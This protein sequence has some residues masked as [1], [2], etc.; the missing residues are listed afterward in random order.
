MG[1][2]CAHGDLGVEAM[3]RARTRR[4]REMR[5]EKDGRAPT[6]RPTSTTFDTR[7]NTREERRR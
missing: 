3:M 2:V 6:A 5:V 1:T 4:E 7:M